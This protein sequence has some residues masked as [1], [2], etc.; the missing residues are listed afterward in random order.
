MILR[1]ELGKSRLWVGQPLVI[2]TELEFEPTWDLAPPDL[3]AVARI[4]LR[5]TISEPVDHIATPIEVNLP[6]GVVA[7]ET[8]D[9]PAGAYEVVVETVETRTIL[10]EL[11]WLLDREDYQALARA[12]AS[13]PF[14]F[15][16]IVSTVGEL[17]QLLDNN[18]AVVWPGFK[19]PFEISW[20]SNNGPISYPPLQWTSEAILRAAKY[21]SAFG[22]S[23]LSGFVS[24][25]ANRLE[26]GVDMNF[27]YPI[28]NVI[29]DTYSDEE[30]SDLY[31]LNANHDLGEF[32]VHIEV[33]Y[34]RGRIA[35][36]QTV[37]EPVYA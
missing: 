2:S 12:E 7:V 10:S 20:S 22:I 17:T 5:S 30:C 31:L 16:P 21:V 4:S 23:D 14:G 29:S 32:D 8:L 13:E 15:E 25:A 6:P 33:S 34:N 36:R 1:C 26:I 18:A 11:I 9:I 28:P 3:S 35:V 19:N 37:P 27:D 24:I